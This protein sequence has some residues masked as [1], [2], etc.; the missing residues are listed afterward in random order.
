MD[1]SFTDKNTAVL[2]FSGR[3]DP[4]KVSSQVRN[5][6]SVARAIIVSRERGNSALAGFLLHGLDSETLDILLGQ[7]SQLTSKHPS[8]FRFN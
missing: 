4:D 1:L 2:T 8:K 6:T 7:I 5:S 3:P